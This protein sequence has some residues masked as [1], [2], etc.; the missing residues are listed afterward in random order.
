M[1]RKIQWIQPSRVEIEKVPLPVPPDDELAEPA[2]DV[3]GSAVRGRVLHK[4]IE[5]ILTG[6]SPDEEA[7]LRIR[8]A[9]LL[10][11]L[12]E[13]DHKDPSKGPSSVEVASTVIRT[14]QLPVVAQYRSA[15]QPEFGVFQ[16]MADEQNTPTGI[17][18]MIDAIACSSDGKPEVVFDWKSDVVPTAETRQHYA[19]QVQ[20]YLSATGTTRGVVVYMTTGETQE[21]SGKTA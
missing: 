13:I 20:E 4:L 21:V 12:G 7:K 15:L 17:A 16:L 5:E 18:G 1:T 19:A 11:Q 9:E 8:A 14:L 6:E 3:R 10:Q 2:P